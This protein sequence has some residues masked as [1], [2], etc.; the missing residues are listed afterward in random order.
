MVRKSKL[1]Y[2]AVCL[3]LNVSA[4]GVEL[5]AVEKNLPS[6]IELYL[7][8]IVENKLPGAIISEPKINI[9]YGMM[10]SRVLCNISLRS[11]YILSAWRF[12]LIQLNERS[13]YQPRLNYNFLPEDCIFRSEMALRSGHSLTSFG[14][15]AIF[16][17]ISHN[18]RSGC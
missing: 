11:A 13:V 16:V 3:E 14:F 10:D 8:D 15:L 6:A 18:L 17:R 12:E 9:E 1:G 7:Q 2:V 5:A 4:S